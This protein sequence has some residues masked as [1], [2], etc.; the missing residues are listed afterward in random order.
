MLARALLAL[1]LLLASWGAQA[2]TLTFTA[3]GVASFTVPPGVFQVDFG[4]YGSAQTLDSFVFPGNGGAGGGFCQIQL[5]VTPG[6]TVHLQ[7]GSNGSGT[8]SWVN[9]SANTEPTSA[10]QGCKASAGSASNAPG[11]GTFGTVN[12]TGGQGF[13]GPFPTTGTGGGGGG[14]GGPGG[15]GHTTSSSAGA[16]GGSSGLGFPAGGAGGSGGAPGSPATVGSDGTQP[17]G[18]GGGGGVDGPG[19]TGN[20]GSG[21]SGKVVAIFVFTPPPTGNGNMFL[22][23][24]G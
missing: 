19:F 5:P 8:D 22:T 4:V 1:I 21:G 10:T 15:N 17:G 3:P 14:G 7:V 20:N 18:G 9:T 6:G 23:W 16:S 24:P 11:T 2:Q 12:T 13:V